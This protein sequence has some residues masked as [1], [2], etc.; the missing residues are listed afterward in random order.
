[1]RRSLILAALSAAAL[2]SA[3]S[4]C[5]AAWVEASDGSLRWVPD[6]MSPVAVP[7]YAESAAS[8]ASV[9]ACST[10]VAASSC[11]TSASAG[12][13]GAANTAARSMPHPVRGLFSFVRA[14]R[15]HVLRRG[16]GGC[17]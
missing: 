16:A 7:V 5:S 6:T 13:C 10:S 14:H 9:A 1:M 3:G 11:G 8:C 12:S 17:P 2:L 4:R 15:P